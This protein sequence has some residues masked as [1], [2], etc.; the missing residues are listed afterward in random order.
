MR[1][2]L[3]PLMLITSSLMMAFAWLGHLK[4][5]ATWSFA[6]ALGA[7]WLLVLPEY[8]LNVGATRWG[9][10]AYTGAQMATMNLASGVVCVA[11]V[12][13]YFL[14]E[15]MGTRQL[16]GFALLVVSTYLIM[17]GEKP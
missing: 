3:V 7:S 2:V 15:P 8:L 9:H 10:G 12:S 11:L 6:F 13:R 17:S 14:D 4:Y 16:L 1:V 5:K